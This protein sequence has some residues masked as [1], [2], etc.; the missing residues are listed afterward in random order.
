MKK[1]NI[2]ITRVPKKTERGFT[3]IETLFSLLL[4]FIALIFIC[5]TLIF[6]I[7]TNR[8]SLIRFEIIQKY[9]YYKYYLCSRPFDSN[10]LKKGDH[11]KY[12]NKF[13]INWI[14][15]SITTSLKK[16][17]I[18]ISYKNLT[19]QNFIY[20]SKFIKEIKNE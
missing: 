7:Y 6:S 4:V 20:K 8:N 2:L 10:E 1:Q 19:K 17:K 3:L 18:K 16:I 12:E 9:E 15:K 13:K 5:K 14:V 11:L